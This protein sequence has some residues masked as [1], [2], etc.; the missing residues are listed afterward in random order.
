M[1]LALFLLLAPVTAVSLWA[2]TPA[3]F[4]NGAI[5]VLSVKSTEV[6]GGEVLLE[7][8]VNRTGAVTSMRSLRETATFTERMT[9]SVQTWKFSPAE[10]EIA[11]ALRKP[12]GPT[13]EPVETR[14]LVAGVFHRPALIGATLGAPIRDVATAATDIPFPTTLITPKYPPRAIGPG[15]VLVEARVDAKGNV[16]DAKVLMSSAP[17]DSAALDAARLWKFRAAKP[18]GVST[19]A[20]VY[21]VF[22]FPVLKS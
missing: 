1:K 7:V 11:P 13:T 14:L 2:G 21:I 22:G 3:L 16:T 10:V 8:S 5:P 9:G 4:Q 12:G 20:V 18:E 6:G 17:F 15:V 19:P